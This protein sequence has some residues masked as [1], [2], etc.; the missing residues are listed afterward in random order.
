MGRGN[1]GRKAGG[2]GSNNAVTNSPE[3]KEWYDDEMNL[4]LSEAAVPSALASNN[5]LD[6]DA[7][8]TQ[9]RG[10]ASAVGDPIRAMER[11]RASIAKEHEDY[12]D[13][14]SA[15]NLGTKAAMEKMLKEYDDAIDRMKRI[16]KN[17]K[18]PDLL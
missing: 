11:Q 15:S 12:K 7:I 4:R 2:A 1:S 13:A 6:D 10:Y 5:N 9:M 16:K 18:R 14:K 17:S 3:F 8:E